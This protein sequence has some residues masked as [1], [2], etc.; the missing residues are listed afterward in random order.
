MSHGHHVAQWKRGAQVV[1]DPEEV[2]SV[3]V[4]VYPA[5]RPSQCKVQI[6]ALEARQ[7]GVYSVSHE[8]VTEPTRPRSSNSLLH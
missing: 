4:A 1:C 3:A 5:N 6:A 7:L 2:R 8:D